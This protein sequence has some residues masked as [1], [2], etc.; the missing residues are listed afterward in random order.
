MQEFRGNIL[1]NETVILE[2]IEG[3]LHVQT[4][5]KGWSEWGGSFRRP[6]YGSIDIG[7]EGYVLELDDGRRGKIIVTRKQLTPG[8]ER[9]EFRGAGTLEENG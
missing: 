9:V 8:G 7:G 1:D 5:S 4:D 2:N 6:K 3:V